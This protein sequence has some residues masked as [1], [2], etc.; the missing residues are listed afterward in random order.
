MPMK[1]SWNGSE[2][3]SRRQFL[4]PYE[5][6]TI[7]RIVRL[8]ILL[9]VTGIALSGVEINAQVTQLPYVTARDVDLLKLLPAPPPNDSPQTESELAQLLAIQATRTPAMEARCNA[10]SVIDVWRFSETFGAKFTKEALPK[11]TSFFGRVVASVGPVIDPA[12]DTWKRQRP[13]QQSDLVKPSVSLSKSASYPSTSSAGAMLMAIVLAN[14]VPEKR[15][16]IMA[17]GW[18]IGNNRIVGGIHFPSDVE[19]GRVSGT[20]IA[21]SLMGRDDFKADFEAAKAELLAALGL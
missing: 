17:R 3:I 20:L 10:D 8:L 5:K 15:T 13:H 6:D 19:A 21:L 9:L 11:L 4:S 2:G 18:E 7:H 1:E 14:M 16:E 12:K